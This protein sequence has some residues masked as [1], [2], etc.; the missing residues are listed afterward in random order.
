LEWLVC[1][2]EKKIEKEEKYQK[3]VSQSRYASRMCWEA[4]IHQIAMEVRTYLELT[5]IIIH[6]S[7]GGCMLRGLVYVNGQV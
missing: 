5:N 7:F 4:A 3:K 1:D 2:C 6:V